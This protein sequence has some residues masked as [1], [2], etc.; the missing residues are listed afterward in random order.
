MKKKERVEKEVDLMIR[1]M[2]TWKLMMKNRMLREILLF[3]KYT[4]VGFRWDFNYE[5]AKDRRSEFV[6]LHILLPPPF[7]LSLSLCIYVCLC[8]ILF[9]C[10]S[11]SLLLSQ[12]YLTTGLRPP[13]NNEHMLGYR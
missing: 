12:V 1:M 11:V 10:L 7:L 6:T 13:L 9:V 4:D 3:Q 8:L 5:S 2:R